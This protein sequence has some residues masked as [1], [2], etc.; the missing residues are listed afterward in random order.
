[1]ANYIEQAIE[2]GLDPEMAI[3]KELEERIVNHLT[4]NNEEMMQVV[5]M[6]HMQE[7]DSIRQ[8]M[9]RVLGGYINDARMLN[10]SFHSALRDLNINWNDLLKPV[11]RVER[12]ESAIMRRAV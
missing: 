7:V 9:M 1:M 2:L 6:Y 5:R 10:A 4:Q 11:K 8:Y 3:E 12:K